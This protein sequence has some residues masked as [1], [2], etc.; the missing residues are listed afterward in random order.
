MP[1]SEHRTGGQASN[2]RKSCR[3]SRAVARSSNPPDFR[4]ARDIASPKS[5]GPLTPDQTK[6]LDTEVARILGDAEPVKVDAEA[7]AAKHTAL[8]EPHNPA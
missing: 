2:R 1:S 3:M 6:A 4:S 5:S 8:G 7:L